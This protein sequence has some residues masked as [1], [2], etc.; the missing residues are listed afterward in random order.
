MDKE[1]NMDKDKNSLEEQVQES[2]GLPPSSSR[3]DDEQVYHFLSMADIKPP[4][5]E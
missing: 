3:Q 2:Y 1:D 5:N 4:V